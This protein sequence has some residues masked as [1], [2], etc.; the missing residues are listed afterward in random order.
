MPVEA[1][2]FDLDGTLVDTAPD[3]HAATNHV[4]STLKR[5]PISMEEVRA[6]VGHGAR[7]LIARGCEATGDPVD[8]RAIETLYQEFVIYYAAHI[9]AF[10]KPFPGLIPFL[11]ACKAKG[12]AMAVCT[13]KLEFL[14]VQLLQA[15]DLAGYFGAVVGPDTIGIAKPD[16]R[17]YHEAL[18]RLGREASSSIMIG[19]SETDIRT[20]QNAG[21][22]VIA[23]SFGYTPQH[24][25]AFN[26]THIID[27]YDE[28]WPIVQ[29]YL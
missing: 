11:D 14:S 28:A 17:P 20:G 16:P 19:D 25:S 22:P 5:R 23:V 21:V 26:P 9:S 2:V 10:S 7:A 3:L 15:L 8:P 1:L 24:V 12:L 4:L 18:K 27:H 29:T 6:F 13:N